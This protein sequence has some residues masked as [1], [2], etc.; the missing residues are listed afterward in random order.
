MSRPVFV[1]DTDEITAVNDRVAEIAQLC[2]ASQS[3]DPIVEYSAMFCLG[4]GIIA[5]THRFNFSRP[6]IQRLFRRVSQ[7]V[8]DVVESELRGKHE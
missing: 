6:K 5:R 3:P 2:R 4:A 1:S 8:G 7:A